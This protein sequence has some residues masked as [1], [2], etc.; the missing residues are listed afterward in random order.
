MIDRI[1]ENIGLRIQSVRRYVSNQHEASKKFLSDIY[2][3]KPV[4]AAIRYKAERTSNVANLIVEQIEITKSLIT[5]RPRL[6]KR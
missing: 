6:L 2:S 3:M 5:R 1:K 4:E